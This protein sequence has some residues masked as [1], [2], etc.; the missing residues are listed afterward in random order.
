VGTSLAAGSAALIAGLVVVWLLLPSLSEFLNHEA[1]YARG[2]IAIALLA[3]G[4]CAVCGALVAA[5]NALSA[6][7]DVPL[8]ALSFALYI[9]VCLDAVAQLLTWLPASIDGETACC[10]PNQFDWRGY[11]ASTAAIAILISI[12]S[13]VQALR[14]APDGRILLIR[15]LVWPLASTLIVVMYD[16]FFDLNRS[17]DLGGLVTAIAVLLAS[18]YIALAATAMLRTLTGSA[19]TSSSSTRRV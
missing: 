6:Y 8:R 12:V 17:G 16:I 18:V 1:I 4:V 3:A 9:L 10:L 14:P 15:S 13:A 11:L 5:P 19:A 7:V 2:L